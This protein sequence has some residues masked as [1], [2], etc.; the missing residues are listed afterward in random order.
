MASFGLFF[1]AGLAAVACTSGGAPPP[2]SHDV[3]GRVVQGGAGRVGVQAMVTVEPGAAA[4]WPAQSARASTDASG[5]FRFTN[6]PDRYDAIVIRDADSSDRALVTIVTGL[7][8]RDPVILLDGDATIEPY[9]ANVVVRGIELDE[10]AS[11]VVV[12]SG[13]AWERHAYAGVSASAAA[14]SHWEATWYGGTSTTA[15]IWLVEMQIDPLTK[16]PTGGFRAGAQFDRLIASKPTFFERSLVPSGSRDVAVEFDVPAGMAITAWRIGL[17]FGEPGTTAWLASGDASNFGQP[18]TLP[19]FAF[20]RVEVEAEGPGERCR[21]ARRGIPNHESRVRV[22]CP[23]AGVISS[24]KDG[25]ASP[26][27]SFSVSWDGEGVCA[28]DLE[29]EQASAPRVRVVT[30]ERSLDVGELAARA[31]ALA[32]GRYRVRTT[33]FGRIDNTDVWADVATARDAATHSRDAMSIALE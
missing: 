12:L 1:G 11:S 2:P 19:E 20:W 25:S 7:T 27:K 15:W 22:G 29:P 17:D 8:R 26:T 9:R 4:D 14:P 21:A 23:V 10:T 16:W 28:I 31:S 30:A 33:N 3:V 18:V 5:T 24:P 32:P 13:P 6:S